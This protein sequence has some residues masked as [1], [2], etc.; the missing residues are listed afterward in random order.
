MSNGDQSTGGLARTPSSGYELEP[1]V[2]V[3]EYRIEGQ[4][5]EGGMGRVYAATHPVIAKRAAIKVLHPELSVNAQAVERFVQEARSVNQIGHPNIV[6]IFAFGALPDGRSYFVM[7]WLRGESLRE[8]MSRGWIPIPE[9][10]QILDTIAVALA[11]AHE[12]GIVH[13]DLKPDNVFLVE[14]KGTAPQVKLLDFGIAKLLGGEDHRSERTRTGNLLGTPAYISP[15]QARGY[16]VDHRT[17][18]YALG[19]VAF[20]MLTG[21]VPFPSDNAADMI[22]R[23]LHE[24]PPFASHRNAQLSPELDQLLRAMLAKD[25]GQRPT[26]DEV[27]ARLRGALSGLRV[28]APGGVQ[29][30]LAL[31]HTSAQLTPPAGHATITPG[32]VA[33]YQTAGTASAKSKAPLVAA[34]GLVVAGLVGAGVYFGAVRGGGEPDTTTTSPPVDQTRPARDVTKSNGDVTKSNGDAIKPAG[35]PSKPA[36]D[37]TTPAGDPTTPAGDPTKPADTATPEPTTPTG[38]P[39]KAADG[40]TKTGA[41]TGKRPRPNG[42][43]GTKTGTKTKPPPTDDPDAPM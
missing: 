38:D 14:I 39:T 10:H 22:A 11:A 9:V 41:K 3:G 13:R 36:G 1:G 21:E 17:D 8:R 30:P 20:E 5:G 2:M 6:D 12:N 18:I 25:P 15:E 16:A 32:P 24:E 7:E 37:S 4:L 42:K 29:T 40:S 31:A 35:D 23:H 43:T 33:T 19:G 34:L 26:L 27:R 28:T